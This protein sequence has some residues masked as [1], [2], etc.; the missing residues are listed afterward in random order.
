MKI[1]GVVLCGGE[2]RRMGSDKG[3]LRLDPNQTGDQRFWAERACDT[4][5]AAGLPVVLSIRAAQRE[6]YARRFPERNLIADDGGLPG[7]LGA[8]LSVSRARRESLFLLAADM[9]FVRTDTVR[10]LLNRFMKAREAAQASESSNADGAFDRDRSFAGTPGGAC[11]GD[12]RRID[13][14]CAVYGAEGLADLDALARQ[15]LARYDL[16]QLRDLMGL[17]VIAPTAEQR[18]ELRNLNAP[19][20]LPE[21]ETNTK[22]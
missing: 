6:E 7:P 21:Y 12:E 13:P 14:L 5:T 17:L 19:G 22:S 2:S 4:L 18:A 11:F 10:L 8:L 20:D 15:G 9:P 3:L 1:C 16:Q